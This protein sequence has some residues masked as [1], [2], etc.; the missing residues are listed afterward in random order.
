MTV[1]NVQTYSQV[2]E[3]QQA[4]AQHKNQQ[5]KIDLQE[6]PDT[7]ELSSNV[8]ET[9]KPSKMK[10]VLVGLAAANCIGLG[11]AIN[12]GFMKGL[13][14]FAGHVGIAGAA[15]A[16]GIAGSLPAAALLVGALAVYDIATIVDAVKN[17]K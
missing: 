10:K 7:V 15:L 5:V 4:I 6:K 1:G 16:V 3:A 17:A 9:K 12:G 14:T 13:Q 11:Q 8:Q 2:F